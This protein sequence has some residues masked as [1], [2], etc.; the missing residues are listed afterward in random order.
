MY[1]VPGI[2]LALDQLLKILNQIILYNSSFTAGWLCLH[3]YTM[4]G[5]EWDLFSMGRGAPLPGGPAPYSPMR[6]RGRPLDHLGVAAVYIIVLWI[7]YVFS[8]AE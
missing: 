6:L 7:F 4:S 2:G 5:R 3:P 8:V 1:F